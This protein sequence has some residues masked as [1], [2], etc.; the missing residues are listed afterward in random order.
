MNSSVY[1]IFVQKRVCINIQGLAWHKVWCGQSKWWRDII[2]SGPGDR[3][4]G[5]PNWHALCMYIRASVSTQAHPRSV[6][7]SV[8]LIAL[9]GL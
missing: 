8:S 5:D 6:R 9:N 2:F 3:G 7:G 4:P 1:T